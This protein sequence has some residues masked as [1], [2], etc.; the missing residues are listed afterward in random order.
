MTMNFHS[1]YESGMDSSYYFPAFRQ[2]ITTKPTVANQLGELAMTLNAG[3]KNVEVGAMQ[4]EN[5]ES[6]PKQHL[7]EMKRLAKL[8]DD[9][10]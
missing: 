6:I 5:L 7:D 2:G 1:D 9:K 10:I 3:V 4:F 8:T